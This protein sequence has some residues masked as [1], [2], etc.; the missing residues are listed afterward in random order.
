MVDLP[1]GI[2]YAVTVRNPG[3][4]SSLRPTDAV[5]ATVVKPGEAAGN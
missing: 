1:L 4:L 2:V 3:I 5:T